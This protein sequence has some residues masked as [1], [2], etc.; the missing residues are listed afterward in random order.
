VLLGRRKFLASL[1]A[2]LAS[3]PRYD[4]L[5]KGGH[6]ID[7]AN[8]VNERRDVAIAG[9]KIAAVR[10]D[11][12]AGQAR[13]V[14]PVDG[15][16]I[17][18]GL[19]DIHVHAFA[20]ITPDEA[21]N[22]DMSLPPDGFTLRAGVTTAV[23]AGSCGW[24]EFPEFKK[25]IIDRAQTRMLAFLNIVGKGMAGRNTV[26]QDLNDMNPEKTAQVAR[27]HSD[28]IVGIKTAHYAGGDWN[29]VDRAVAAGKLANIP[30]MVDYGVF[31]PERPYSQ[32]LLDHLRP[33][34]ISTHMFI[35]PA[36]L[37]D[38]KGRVHDYMRLARRRGVN[39]DVGHGSGSFVW[40]QAE[41]L[42]RQGFYPDSIS[43]D[44][45]S[46]SMNG[47]MKD[48]NNVMSKILC[49]GV[50]FEQVIRMSTVNPADEI[51]RPALGRLTTGLEADLAVLRR[52]R[53]EF[54]YVDSRGTYRP[55]GERI[56]CELTLRAGRAVWDRDGRAAR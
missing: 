36:P 45:H 10:G 55:G 37:L 51:H 8:G 53:G 12:P 5:L 30:V 22:G 11:I 1:A 7:P 23:D 21:A 49:L 2:P 44:L 31:R 42:I 17:T 47:G 48:M 4:V 29:A 3:Q 6:V 9:G 41:P 24:R 26:E 33:G 27:Q 32:L 56:S 35:E 13:R 40:P 20:G 25:R 16:Y 19:I 28:C 38:E 50:P 15:L 46:K 43:T 18:P 39:F 52:E 14:I 54:G 34:D